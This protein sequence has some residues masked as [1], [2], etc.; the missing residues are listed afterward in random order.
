MLIFDLNYTVKLTLEDIP[1]AAIVENIHR[2]ASIV[3]ILDCSLAILQN[4]IGW[5]DLQIGPTRNI[6]SC[7]RYAC[8]C[9]IAPD[10]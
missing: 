8:I 9:L 4:E 5:L 1:V 2:C 3:K 7:L 10:G 6:F